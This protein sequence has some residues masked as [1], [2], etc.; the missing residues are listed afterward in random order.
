MAE[1]LNVESHLPEIN[2]NFHNN[3]THNSRI[4]D[5]ELPYSKLD[6]YLNRLYLSKKSIPTTINHFKCICYNSVITWLN[7]TC[8]LPE[9]DERIFTSLF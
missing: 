1:G 5:L 2:L 9:V 4:S 6:G 3:D 8:S 7:Y